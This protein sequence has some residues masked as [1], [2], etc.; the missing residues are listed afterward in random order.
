[1]VVIA[2]S[3]VSGRISEI[4]LTNVVLPTAKPPATSSLTDC[5]SAGTAGTGSTGS[6]GWSEFA[7]SIEHLLQECD[8]VSVGRARRG[9][10]EAVG[11]EVGDEDPGD[12]DGESRAGGDLH[13]RRWFAAQGED[14]ARL[15]GRLLSR[16]GHFPGGANHRFES[17]VGR[18]GRGAAA[19]D[20][21]RPDEARAL[22]VVVHRGS[23][24]CS[25][26]MS[27]GVSPRPIF[28]MSTAISYA[29]RPMS[30]G[31]VAVT[32]SDEPSLIAIVSNRAR[33]I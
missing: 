29:M 20:H 33:S 25:S 2:A 28:S 21:V 14:G 17:E 22:A 19:G 7:Y 13:E 32:A 27:C 23:A 11:G 10:Q 30:H 9:F 24:C 16:R 15:D 26:A 31:R 8:V 12:P 3:V 1:M 5:G 4:E 18:G 6:A